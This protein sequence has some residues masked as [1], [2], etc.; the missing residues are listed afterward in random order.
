MSFKFVEIFAWWT[1]NT[2]GTRLWTWR[3]GERVGEDQFG[4]T[5][6]RT[7]GGKVDPTLGFQR[8]WVIYNGPAEASRIPPGWHGWIHHRT[9]VAPVDETYVARDWELPHTENLTGTAGAYR[10]QGSLLAEGKRV[11]VAADYQPWV[12]GA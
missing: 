6:Y 1:G 10:P 5:Y 8:R 4:N 12:P 11:S 3:H 7:R 2:I 9:D